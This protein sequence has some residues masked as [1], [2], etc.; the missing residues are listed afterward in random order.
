MVDRLSS[1]AFF[2]SQQRVKVASVP[3][4]E[5]EVFARFE[6]VKEEIHIAWR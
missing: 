4:L 6:V 3:H 2:D 5:I 1:L